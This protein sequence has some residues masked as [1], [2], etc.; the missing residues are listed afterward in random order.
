M[1]VKRRRLCAVAGC[2]GGLDAS[3]EAS[4]ECAF[5]GAADVAVGLAFGGASGLVGA[6]FWVAAHPG[7]GDGVQGAVEVAVAAAVESVTGA[8]AAAGFERRDAGQGG[9]CG[10]VAD[11]SA[12]GPADQQLGGDDRSDAGF[13]EQRR[14]GRVLL[15]QVEQLGIELGDLGGE[16]P[17]AGGD[18][19]QR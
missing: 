4:G 13:G 8:L 2:G 11:P 16:E 14:P 9:E 1:F 3:V 7:D 17:D 18:R 5:E 19:L 10:F 15:D 6:G 12:V